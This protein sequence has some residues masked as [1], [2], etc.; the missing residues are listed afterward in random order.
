M[1]QLLVIVLIEALPIGIARSALGRNPFAYWLVPDLLIV[2]ELYGAVTL[3]AVDHDSSTLL[4]LLKSGARRFPSTLGAMLLSL[5]WL[6][7]FSVLV[8]LCAGVGSFVV[9]LAGF[10]IAAKVA[11]YIVGG[12][13]DLV[14]LPV[15]ALEAMTLIP[16]TILEN[17]S[18]A[19]ALSRTRQRVKRTGLWRSWLLGLTAFAV[20]LVPAL[21][22]SG[23][24]DRAATAT[25]I[26]ALHALDEFLTDATTLGFGAVFATV[27]CLEMRLRSEGTDI[28]A[29]VRRSAV[30]A[31]EPV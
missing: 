22:C 5:V 26:A 4:A 30:P 8:V 3:A 9:S 15:A 20:T 7:F 13:A 25:H 6:G 31:V 24:L 10:A 27:V 29:A 23:I 17:V 11:V 12:A 28:A 19:E 1:A 16:I 21:I 18:A 14:F 2:V